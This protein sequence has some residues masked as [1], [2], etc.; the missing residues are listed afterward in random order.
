MACPPL[1]QGWS[2]ESG[3]LYC[4]SGS[5]RLG[6]IFEIFFESY[7]RR[8]TS[9]RHAEWR[10]QLKG[11][12]RFVLWR[13]N[14][15]NGAEK[16]VAEYFGD[17]SANEVNIVLRAELES[18]EE[19]SLQVEVEAAEGAVLSEIGW[20]ARSPAPN[21]IRLG[22]VITTYEREAF[23]R[24][25]LIRLAGQSNDAQLVIVNHGS[26]G[27][28][29]RMADAVHGGL[30][31]RFID[32]ENSGGAGGF[33]RGM[34]E[35]RRVGHASHILLMDDDIDLPGDL[36]ERVLAVLAWADQ[37]LCL[38]GAMFD[39]HS[40]TKLFSAGDF[41]LPGSFGI[42]HVAPS[43]GGDAA[44]VRDV[45]FLAR[46]HTPDFNAW[47]CFAFPVDAMDAVGLP[48]PCFIRGDDVEYGYRLK[49]AGWPTVCWPGIAVW[50][51]PFAEKAAPWQMFYDRRNS[52]F[53]NAIHGRVQL[54]DALR[55]LTGGFFHHLLRYDYD[56]VKAMT[57]GI[58]AFNQGASAMA[59]WTDTDH[60][61]LLAET[62]QH[63]ARAAQKLGVNNRMQKPE[64]LHGRRRSVAMVLRL[65]SD[66]F[67]PRA[68]GPALWLMPNVAWRPDYLRRP[69]LAVET[70]MDGSPQRVFCYDRRESWTALWQCL[71]ALT[72]MAWRFRQKVELPQLE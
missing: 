66:L 12:A 25:N 31:V 72:G 5:Q 14:A 68:K 57:S 53:A 64:R 41:L 26:P 63:S 48:M 15:T 30:E 46:L 65:L 8:F 28:H 24:A 23:L 44:V 67:L 22:L 27:L 11:K 60:R 37:P 1:R 56:R 51:M 71:R 18:T 62:N 20:Y 32:Q 35:H 33:T 49:R 4:G 21:L 45:D 52:L 47:W 58:A 54:S 36:I 29:E 2:A 69:R 61:R 59:A 13:R 7:W 55:K 38:G 19:S 34:S 17:G 40:R 6:G 10:C 50:H 16:Q 43:G 42:G 3:I 39:Y 70:A 9:L